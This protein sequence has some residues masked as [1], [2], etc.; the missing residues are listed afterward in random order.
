MWVEINACP[1]ED[2]LSIFFKNTTAQKEQQ[3]KYQESQRR[4]DQVLDLSSEIFWEFDIVTGK[5]A[6]QGNKLAKL[7]DH[8]RENLDPVEVWENHVHP[9]DLQTI[10][11]SFEAALQNGESFYTAQYRLRKKDGEYIHVQDRGQIIRNSKG[12]PIKAIGIT[13]DITATKLYEQALIQA[14][15]SYQSL[16]DLSPLPRWIYDEV[17]LRF[18]DV[19][20]AATSHYGYSRKEFL[21]MTI[22]NLHPDGE[23]SRLEEHIEY[24]QP[25]SGMW[26][27]L[28]K[29]GKVILVEISEVSLEFQNKRACL[30]T[31]M[32]ITEKKKTE[33]ALKASEQK[34]SGILESIGDGL[35]VVDKNWTITYLN[36]KAEN[37]LG[38]DKA[39]FLD[40]H[41]WEVFNDAM[42]LNSYREYHRAMKENVPVR[43][44]DYYP[45]LQSWFE[46]SAY[47]TT[48]GLSIYFN[49]ITE[50]KRQQQERRENQQKLRQAEEDLQQVLE[51]MTD[52]FYTV[53]RNWKIKFATDKVAAMLAVNKEDYMGKNLWDCFPEA[54]N[55][56]IYTQFHRAFASGMSVSFEE[57]NPVYNIW[58]DINAYPQGDV[59]AVYVKDITER[60][61]N[62]K[63]LEFIA[64]A[65]SEVIWELD[66]ASRQAVI[67]REK[68]QSVFG[69]S[70][71]AGCDPFAFWLD[72][73]HPE[74]VQAIHKKN[75]LALEQ[76]L[77]FYMHEY[78]LKKSDGSWAYVKD[79][80][81]IVRDDKDQP[82]RLIG[83]MED[84]TRERVAEK[85]LQE[86]EQTYKQ[87]FDLAS[88][89][90]AVY[91]QENLRIL[92]VNQ[93]AIELY[94]YSRK[95]FLSMNI[96]EIRPSEDQIRALDALSMARPSSRTNLGVWTHIKKG[97]E[98]MLA[99]VS[100]ATINYRGKTC[101]LA[102]VLDVT[103]KMKLQEQLTKEKVKKQQSITRA[104]LNAQEKERTEISRELHDG[105]NQVLTTAKLYVE[106]IKYY[107]EQ[108]D[109]FVEKSVSLLQN[110]INE[111]RAMSKALVS[112]TIT[113]LGF[114]EALWELIKCYRELNLFKIDYTFNGTTEKIE[115]EIKLTLYRIIQEQLNNIVKYAKASIVHIGIQQADRKLLVI[116]EDNGI[117]FDTGQKKNGLGLSNIKNRAELFNGKAKIDSAPGK[118][119]K[120]EIAFPL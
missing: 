68:F 105:V 98:R 48:D 12:E 3:Q 42:E 29:N 90:K 28:K 50:K 66:L 119:C 59:L 106:N 5:A 110:S 93:A 25:L 24:K 49:N 36:G 1:Q 102:T 30:C 52:G 18:L 51:S 103:E 23:R 81:Y 83:A 117:G 45:A 33:L 114:N 41:L 34:L 61:N 39:Y 108:K 15:A 40:R 94:G 112:P 67:N 96:L 27:H 47:P 86:S 46:I 91:D 60:K 92:N 113:D 80:V 76:N 54:V 115:Q 74:D 13:G 99:E 21:Q 107:P 65:T 89:P 104:T 38:H 55:T 43:F 109:M 58:F 56:K 53:D 62:E 120:I 37:L 72:K 7:L 16:F 82:T 118:G 14:R 6:W 44:E 57:Y 19:N 35:L 31:L 11:A 9:G 32:D 10:R 79:R 63:R 69:Y 20:Q 8:D 78:R 85:A 111:I 88:L 71:P 4:L 73:V 87:L 97:G 2:T 26:T 116:I 17:S 100:V 77:G 22:L 70:L 101:K 84:V 64:R 75:N 95:E